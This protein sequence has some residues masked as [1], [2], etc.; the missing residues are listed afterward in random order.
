MKGNKGD[1]EVKVSE[2]SIT[3][4]SYQSFI[5]LH[6]LK[7]LTFALVYVLWKF[8]RNVFSSWYHFAVMRDLYSLCYTWLYLIFIHDVFINNQSYD[9]HI[10]LWN[11]AIHMQK[12]ENYRQHIKV[13][14]FMN[15]SCLGYGKPLTCVHGNISQKCPHKQTGV[16]HS[17]ATHEETSCQPHFVH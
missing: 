8:L 17:C 13:E 3:L 7:C 9:A 16:R 5:S 2:S 14:I 12:T 10:F 11:G 6:R 1:L 15:L 4:T